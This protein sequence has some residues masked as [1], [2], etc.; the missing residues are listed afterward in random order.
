MLENAS[1]EEIVRTNF[2]QSSGIPSSR[3]LDTVNG[4][5]GTS[6]PAI[7]RIFALS[8]NSVNEIVPDSPTFQRS[9]FELTIIKEGRAILVS[10]T[11]GVAGTT[12]VEEFISLNC[13]AA[14]SRI[15][16]RSFKVW[17]L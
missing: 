3:T 7:R 17:E 2:E 8:L 14:L 4:S 15:T 9:P 11:L 6:H 12:A 16:I 1:R 10:L 13:T 5:Y